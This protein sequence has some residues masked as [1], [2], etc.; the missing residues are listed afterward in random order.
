MRRA[1]A[2]GRGHLQAPGWTRRFKAARFA[3]VIYAAPGST[4]TS[5][6]RLSR[7]HRAGHVYVTSLT[8]PYANLPGYWAHEDSALTAGCP[9]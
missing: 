4:L 2:A 6:I 5:A 8:D 1:R 9:G 3:H 7:T